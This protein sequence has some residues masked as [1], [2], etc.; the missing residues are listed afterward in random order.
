MRTTKG[1]MTKLNN[2]TASMTFTVRASRRERRQYPHKATWRWT[3]E[4]LGFV[5]TPGCDCTLCRRDIDCC[6]QMVPYTAKLVPTKRGF[7]VVQVYRRNI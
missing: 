1:Y 7:K 3:L 6:G 2:D 4:D 5:Q